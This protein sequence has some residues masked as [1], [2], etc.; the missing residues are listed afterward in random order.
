MGADANEKTTMALLD[1]PLRRIIEA[2]NDVLLGKDHSVRLAL[3]CLLAGGHL[4][5]EDIPGVG[6][7]TLAQV[8]ARALG[9]DYRRIQFTSDLL[10]ADVIG[11]SV[12]QREQATFRFHA[13]PVFSQVLLADEIN[14]GTPRTQSALL[15]AMEEGQVTVDGTTHPL[16]KPFL[17]IAT[18]NPIDQI[19]TFALPESQLDRFLMRLTLGY[20]DPAAERALLAGDDR[21]AL[22]AAFAPVASAEQLLGWRKT[23]HA[24]HASPALIDY[25]QTLAGE[26]R[27]CGLFEAGL[28]PR[29]TIALLNAARSWA[30]LHADHKVT[31]EHV[32]AVFTA[33]AGHRLRP[34]NTLGDDPA[35]LLRRLVDSVPLR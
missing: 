33:V 15:E 31:P 32:Q 6:K 22:L 8:L 20:P 18:Q 14:R 25:V 9:L 4:L 2:V 26:S 5:I 7:T 12:F 11:V 10:P 34:R 35:L 28:S 13:G 3:S 24:V 1:S 21:R 30:F 16:P 23:V 27:R 29:G 19:G 17:V